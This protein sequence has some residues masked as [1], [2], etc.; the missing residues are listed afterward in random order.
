MAILLDADSRVLIQ[1][2]TGSQG[3]YH[4][5]LIKEYGTQIVAGV[6]PGR[7]GEEVHGIPVYDTVKE[8]REYAG[9]ID[10]SMILVPPR[11]VKDAAVEAIENDVPII[12]IITE[13]VPVHDTMYLR[14]L[15]RQRGVWLVGPNTIGIISPGKCKLGIMAS[16]LYPPGRIGMMS[17]SG[18][19]SH[20]TASNLMYRGLGLSTVVGIG[21][22]PVVGTDFVDLLPLFAADPETEAV[23]MIGEIGGNKEERAA[24]YLQRNS[25]PKPVF[26]FIAGQTA[27]PGKQMGHAGAIIEGESGRADTKASALAA[28]GARVAGSL[29][30]LVEMVASV[31][32]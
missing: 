25:F 12:I 22:D 26:A 14:A 1:G 19:L 5:R 18:T 16:F 9:K 27:P 4:A 6:T 7:G 10:A 31:F 23:I 17:R 15:A 11:A 21:G 30:E 24:E 2:I 3:A 32:K 20:E 29:E 8:A 28:A 13:H